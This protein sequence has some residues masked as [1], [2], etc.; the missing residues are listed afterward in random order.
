MTTFCWQ[1]KEVAEIKKEPS[2]ALEKIKE[3][4]EKEKQHGATERST[5]RKEELKV[6]LHLHEMSSEM[7]PYHELTNCFILV[8]ASKFGQK[9]EKRRRREG[10]SGTSCS[11]ESTS[12]ETSCA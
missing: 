11:S 4:E 1:V 7:C 10:A 12:D 3:I 6:H 8:A 5:K 9:A 2:V